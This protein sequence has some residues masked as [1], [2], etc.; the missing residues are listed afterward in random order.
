MDNIYY[1]KIYY[2]T[3]QLYNS[4]DINLEYLNKL[5]KYTDK[6]QLKY[7]NNP[8][9]LYGGNPLLLL[10]AA[11]AIGPG[12]ILK[13][14]NVIGPGNILNASRAIG[15]G[16]ILNGVKI[17]NNMNSSRGN[18]KLP[19]NINVD[20][21]ANTFVNNANKQINNKLNEL[22]NQANIKLNQYAN[23][24]SKL[25]SDGMNLYNKRK[26][27]QQ[28][29]QQQ[30]NQQYQ[31]S[32]FN[33]QPQYNQQYQQPQFN[34][35]PQYNQQYQQPQFNQQQ[36]FNQQYSQQFNQQYQQ[37]QFNQQQQFNQQ[38]SQ[39][40]NQQQPDNVNTLK[41]M[42]IDILNRY[43]NISVNNPNNQILMNNINQMQQLIEYNTNVM[44]MNRTGGKYKYNYKRFIPM[45]S[46]D[47]YEI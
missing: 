8:F 21:L 1:N 39:S 6:F 34:Q 35:Q 11:N 19:G 29:Q 46:M 5:F 43:R 4:N 18:L 32:Q 23:D 37:P 44:N 17:M 3:K 33:Q 16:N 36:Q 28:Q 12:N 15:T 38:Y 9:N 26:Q 13:A 10:K 41:N 45:Y 30:Y 40:F 20:K 47:K 22:G 2:Y 25:L 42:I 14:A 27:Q 24:P 31:Q 7:N